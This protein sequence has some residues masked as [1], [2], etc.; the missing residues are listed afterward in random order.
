MSEEE[1][2]PEELAELGEETPA[3][4]K[5]AKRG[6]T[7]KL[8][9]DKPKPTVEGVMATIKKALE[10]PY[11]AARALDDAVKQARLTLRATGNDLSKA[12][13]ALVGEADSDEMWIL[14]P[15]MVKTIKVDDLLKLLTDIQEKI[16]ESGIMSL[17]KSFSTKGA[18]LEKSVTKLTAKVG[19]PKS[20]A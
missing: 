10:A 5:T 16:A 3:T 12:I 14:N 8:A 18:V 17:S 9:S 6:G 2:T 15:K 20:A 4:P 7:I 11:D 13:S 19:R 1:F